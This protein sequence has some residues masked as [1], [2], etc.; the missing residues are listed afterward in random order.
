MPDVR[1]LFPNGKKSALTFSYDDGV[2]ADRR[3]VERF[4]HYGFKGTFNLNTS[5]LDKPDHLTTAELPSLFTGHEVAVHA[6]HHPFLERIARSQMIGELLADRQNLE[7]IFHKPITGLAYPYGTYDPEVLATLRAMGFAYAR[8]AGDET[9]CF[10]HP[11]DWLVWRPT[12]HHKRALEFV[13]MFLKSYHMLT[14]FYIWG[15]SYE[16]DRDNNWELVDQI[17]ERL[18]N[19]PHVWYVTNG[20]LQHYLDSIHRL[21]FTVDMNSVYNPTDCRIWLQVGKERV[22]TLAPGET[23]R[24]DSVA[25]SL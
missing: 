5:I 24:L 10:R 3:L 7:A 20:E 15:H 19:Q 1:Y 22:L 14:F 25:E 2:A 4:N 8:T 11:Q 17:G 23:I 6:Y 12:C 13:D 21:I 18:T 16:F 9:G